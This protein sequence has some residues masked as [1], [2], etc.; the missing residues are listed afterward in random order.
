M[1]TT[2]TIKP[3]KVYK[4]EVFK[5]YIQHRNGK[6]SYCCRWMPVAYFA[7]RQLAN[8]VAS[9]L[10]MAHIEA[11]ANEHPIHVMEVNDKTIGAIADIVDTKKGMKIDVVDKSRP[12]TIYF[13]TCK[14]CGSLYASKRMDYCKK[15]VPDMSKLN[16]MKVCDLVANA[17][18]NNA[19]TK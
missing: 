15:C 7:S 19:T 4:L 9:L 10:Q 11:T 1:K 16:R 18:A 8:Y 3:C 12:K 2:E 17:R 13:K 5:P 6:N 14:L